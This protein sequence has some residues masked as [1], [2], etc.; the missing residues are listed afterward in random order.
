V[1]VSIRL[2]RD[3]QLLD[4]PRKS[5]APRVYIQG[6]HEGGYAISAAGLRILRD[7][8]DERAKFVAAATSFRSFL[9][10]WYF[11]PPGSP[12]TLLGPNLW[13]AQQTYVETAS[14]ESRL[15]YLKAR[16]LGETTIACAF[17]AWVARFG[18]QSSR[19][20]LF[21]Q[22]DQNAVEMLGYV[23][24]GLEA[25]PPS[26]RLPVKIT[27]HTLTLSAGQGDRRIVKSYPANAATRGSTCTH[28]H[29]DELAIMVDPLKTWAAIEPTVQPG[30]SIHVL[31][32]GAGPVGF[33]ADLWRAAVAGESEFAPCFL[34]ALQRPDRDEAWMESKRRS[35]DA[36]TFSAEYPMKWE[37]AL[38]GAGEYLFES[39]KIDMASFEAL[40]CYLTQRQYEHDRRDFHR[41]EPRRRY[42][43]GVDVGT[44]DATVIT[45]LDVTRRPYQV[46]GWY[47]L[48]P[49]TIGS[50]QTL[51]AQAHR[52]WPDAHL[53]LEDNGL[54]EGI[55]ENARVPESHF[56]GIFQSKASKRGMIGELQ[57]HINNEWIIWN[58]KDC[59]QLDT[60][61]RAYKAV[62]ENIRQDCV[63]SLALALEAAA[64][65]TFPEPG[66]ILAVMHC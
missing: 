48:C 58:P 65:A 18:P 57:I 39:E 7:D 2:A 45:I 4:A 56:K 27:A 53:L 16:Q 14:R 46:V 6:G 66:R 42:V 26:M 25:L 11:T 31:T 63:M 50:I 44:V 55:R 36:R 61:M 28:C 60:E 30:G 38:A 62:D 49:A 24:F 21:C 19:V 12:P 10:S 43:G 13:P 64:S 52:D 41:R 54:G 23:G 51:V 15:F 47:Y 5:A 32:T 29:V 33:A 8:P 22:R 40:G 17:D 1:P 35:T 59:P 9:D 34:D 20:H 37:D 3:G